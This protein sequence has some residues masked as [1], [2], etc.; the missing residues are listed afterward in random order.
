VLESGVELARR[1]RD[2]FWKRDPA[3]G[4]RVR[5]LVAASIGSYGAYL[6]DGSEYRGNYDVGVDALMDWHR[7]RV[8]IFESTGA[9]LLAFETI[10]SADEAAAIVRLLAESEGPPAW[11]S[12]QA[13]DEASLADG[14][15]V[16]AAVARAERCARVVAV[17]VNCVAPALVTPLLVRCATATRKPLVAYPNRGGVWDATSKGWVDGGEAISF[18]RLAREWRAAGARLIGGCCRTTPAD[19]RV[20]AEWGQVSH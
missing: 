14:T 8:R 6:A 9:D 4:G 18:D 16:E 17:G 7:P 19:I 12:F 11:I 5:P 13:R 10:P 2:A 15:P 3:G 20:L 1:E